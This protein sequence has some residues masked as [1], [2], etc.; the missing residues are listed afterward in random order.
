M[1]L[2]RWGVNL[3]LDESRWENEQALKKEM[4]LHM[5]YLGGEADWLK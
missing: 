4:T 3:G 2:D 1:A 5:A